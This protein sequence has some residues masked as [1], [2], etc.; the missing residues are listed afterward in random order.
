[1]FLTSLDLEGV[2][3]PE[4]WI[5][6]AERTGIEKLK[7]TTR[8]ISDY[9]KLMQY[10]LKILDEK[11]LTLKVIQDAIDSMDPFPG[12]VDFLEWLRNLCQVVI[13]SDTY[14]EFA[15]PIMKKLNMPTILCHSLKVDENNKISSYYLRIDDAKRKAV[16]SFKSLNFETIAC[17][18]SFNDIGMLEEAD[19]GIFFRPPQEISV[20]YPGFPVT[21]NYN[22][23]KSI[24]SHLINNS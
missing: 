20:Q 2:L 5:T 9:D 22:E 10:R 13:L 11:N 6:V 21:H 7:L 16:A 15:K 19:H 1:M 3:F 14:I 23:L 24:I 17:G 4:V 18:D 8:D 12:A